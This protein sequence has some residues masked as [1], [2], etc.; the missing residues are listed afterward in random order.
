VIKEWIF[1]QL[2]ARAQQAVESAG[3]AL[4]TPEVV[5]AELHFSTSPRAAIRLQE[6][7]TASAE[8][9]GR[10]ATAMLQFPWCPFSISPH[11]FSRSVDGL[12]LFVAI[13]LFS[14]LAVSI[15]ESVPPWPVAIPLLLTAAVLLSG[16][17]W[18]LFMG[19]IGET[20]GAHLARIAGGADAAE[21]EEDRPRFR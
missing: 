12:I 5:P 20:P 9:S 2:L 17:Y 14:V 10:D 16:A 11:A 7:V 18:F 15:T 19:W 3:F 8:L 4:S 13:M 21:A 1:T 6:P